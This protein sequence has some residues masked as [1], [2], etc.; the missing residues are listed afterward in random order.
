[1]HR[2]DDARVYQRQVRQ[3]VEAGH[4][5]V[6]IAPAMTSDVATFR[7]VTHIVIRALSDGNGWRRG[8]QFEKR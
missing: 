1:M 3:L 2:G 5:V 8:G 7:G 4:R 6:Y